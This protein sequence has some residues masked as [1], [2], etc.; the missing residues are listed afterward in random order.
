MTANNAFERNV[1]HRGPRVSRG[2]VVSGRPLNS[3]VSRHIRGDMAHS[4]CSVAAAIVAA[5]VGV[6]EDPIAM[7]RIDDEAGSFGIRLNMDGSCVALV[8]P[9]DGPAHLVSCTYQVRNNVIDVTWPFLGGRVDKRVPTRFVFLTE[10]N[11][12]IADGVPEK[13]L[14]PVTS[15]RKALGR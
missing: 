8:G 13:P 1:A 7:W 11:V 10:E 12:L 6:A 14:R 15:A 4:L 9:I 3:I 2:K 5:M